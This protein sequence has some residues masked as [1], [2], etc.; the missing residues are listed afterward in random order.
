MGDFRL[1]KTR[2][3]GIVEEYEQKTLGGTV[4]EGDLLK[5]SSGTLIKIT[6]DDS[7]SPTFL[8][9]EAGDSGDEITVLEL[10][11]WIRLQGVYTGTEPDEGALVGIDVTTNVIKIDGAAANTHFAYVRTINS[12]TKTCVVQVPSVGEQSAITEGV[13]RTQKVHVAHSD[14]SAAKS[15]VIPAG[16]VLMGA[17]AIC[18]EAAAGSPDVD[19]GISE[20]DTDGI[21]DDLGGNCATLAAVL[22]DDP[23]ATGVGVLLFDSQDSAAVQTFKKPHYAAA[24][25]FINT[26]NAAGTGGEWDVYMSYIKLP[27]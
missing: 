8:A 19:W 2:A 13:V 12:T 11:P 23:D 10:V 3:G 5:W 16:S 1:L 18:T 6:D 21:F 25:T 9:L 20:G 15:I 26:Q 7:T 22:G 4:E 24:T 17:W 14:A 27:S